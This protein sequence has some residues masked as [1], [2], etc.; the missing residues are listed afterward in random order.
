[1]IFATFLAA[2]AACITATAAL[3]VN[4]DDPSSIRATSRTLAFG[5]QSYY[6]NNLSSTAPTA[7]GTL[8][9]PLYW[10]QAGAMWG[11]MIDYWAYTNDTSYNEVTTQ[12]LLAQVGPDW[13]YMPPAYFS[14]L[15]N[16]DQAFW[17]L[18]VLSAEE[19]GF[20]FPSGQRV[21]SWLDLAAAV[22][23]TQVARWNTEQCGGG[24]K[25]QIFDYNKGWNYRNSI[26]NGAF[27]QISAR[28]AHFTGNQTY[29]EW[30]GK[31][32]DW[33]D[34]IGLISSN[35]QVFD[36]SDDTLNC[37]ELD[38]TQWTYNPAMLLYG[39]AMMA[40]LTNE[41]VWKDRADGL[42]TSIENTFFLPGGDGDNRIDDSTDVMYEAACEP[43]GTC[44]NDQFS[45][46]AYL[47]R[48]LAK[49][50]VV[51][52]GVTDSI[53]KRLR[54]SA[55]A[56]AQSCSGGADGQTCGQKWYTGGFDGS[57]GVGQSMSALETLQSLLLL[58][59]TWSPRRV[60]LVG[61][62]VTIEVVPVTSTFP[63]NPP[64]AT[65]NSGVTG[66]DGNGPKRSTGARTNFLGSTRRMTS[67]S[68]TTTG[69]TSLTTRSLGNGAALKTWAGLAAPVV[70]AV[71]MGVVL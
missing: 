13:N 59:S 55:L 56:A 70:V 35:Y 71:A 52:P 9:A 46:K 23:D 27:L 42:L 45:F 2:L 63:L 26:S 21:S 40:N 53:A 67:T 11:G 62:N 64:T 43:F 58:H 25:W 69:R 28:L 30:A 12:A 22:W 24:L 7:I 17:A 36:G 15:G 47:S 10:W 14:S 19:Y 8:P 54:A 57:S 48:W 6:Q 31:T 50:A 39:T 1:M 68:L 49:S 4:I 37:S 29:V 20:P 16:D 18:A 38:H 3:E 32:W 33:M 41:Q 65:S 5:L 51:Y 44:N 60:P 34:R 66:G 61:P